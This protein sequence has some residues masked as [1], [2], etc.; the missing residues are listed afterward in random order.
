MSGGGVAAAWRGSCTDDSARVWKCPSS[1]LFLIFWTRG[2][3][4]PTSVCL[5]GFAIMSRSQRGECRLLGFC[6]VFERYG[7]D[8]SIL[9]VFVY[10]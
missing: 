3:S 5:D 1:L 7:L 4:S 10:T 9:G 8:G 2:D 6:A